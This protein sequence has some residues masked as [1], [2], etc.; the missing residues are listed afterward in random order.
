MGTLALLL[1]SRGVPL[2]QALVFGLSRVGSSVLSMGS[3]L[4]R[5]TEVPREKLGAVNASIRMHFMAGAPL[6]ALFQGFII[7]HFRVGNFASSRSVLPLGHLLLRP[8]RRPRLR[9]DRR[10]QNPASCLAHL[11]GFFPC[12]AEDVYVRCSF[13]GGNNQG[14]FHV[15]SC[16]RLSIRCPFYIKLRK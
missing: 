15:R 12:D 1:V 3:F 16:T 7:K 2:G 13:N 6:S 10:R 9:T 11:F 4:I 8:P 5:Q 14:V